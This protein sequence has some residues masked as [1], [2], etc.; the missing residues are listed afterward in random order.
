MKS[1][2][3]SLLA[4]ALLAVAA[5]PGCSSEDPAEAQPPAPAPQHCPVV[6]VTCDAA[7]QE[8]T[9][10]LYTTGVSGGDADV[11]PT[12]NWSVSAGGISSGQGTSSITVDSSSIG[13]ST[14]TASVEVG[15]YASE[16]QT[17]A[18]C[19]VAVNK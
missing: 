15:G 2:H 10:L 14:V 12:F 8:G 17:V 6:E 19:S 16:C 5:S 3:A 9:Q 13:G 4:S 11:G 7:A 18:S 1:I